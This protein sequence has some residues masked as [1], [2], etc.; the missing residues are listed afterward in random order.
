MCELDE[1]NVPLQE[2]QGSRAGQVI[3]FR[4]LDLCGIVW[5]KEVLEMRKS[6]FY[7]SHTADDGS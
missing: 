3:L 4:G 5:V 1:D 7:T 6:A 2:R